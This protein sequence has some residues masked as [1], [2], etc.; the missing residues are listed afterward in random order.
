MDMNSFEF[1]PWDSAFFGYRVARV[2]IN[3]DDPYDYEQT[4]RI[5]DQEQARLTYILVSPEALRL[6]SMI[7]E[8]GGLLV[9]KKVTFCKTSASH[10]GFRNEIM[11]YSGT[12]DEKELSELALQAGLYSRF[13]IDCNF[14][15]GE[16]ERLYRKWLENSLNGKVAFSVII[17]RTEERISGLITLGARGN[18]ADIGLLAVDRSYVG[19]GIGT[20]LVYY[21]DNEANAKGF[22][23]I[24]VVTQLDNERACSL[25]EKCGFSVESLLN[26]YHMWL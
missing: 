12:G 14:R 13:R 9:D 4:L 18:F 20:E 24:K 2:V 7:K 19:M 5:L 25:Y 16:Y 26:I 3:N 17:A 23:N 6:N 21:A 1:L 22:S 10:S 11:E 15:N 8:S